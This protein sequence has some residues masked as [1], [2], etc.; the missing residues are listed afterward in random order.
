[1]H[2]SRARPD[3]L[4]TEFH[5]VRWRSHALQR[6]AR[7]LLHLP[8]DYS[9]RPARRY[10]VLYFLHGSGHDPHSVMEQ[11]CPQEHRDAL[12]AALLVVPEGNQGWWLDSPVQRQSNFGQY[13]LELVA[14]IDERY[15]T[16]ATPAGRGLCGF[17]MGGY[18]AM[19]LTCQHPDL[20]GSASSLLGPLDISQMF[21]NY[22]RLR[23][24]LGSSL[25]A[26]QEFN[27]TRLAARLA[28]T[29]LYFCTAQEAFDR[30]QNE[31]FAAA[32]R[33]LGIAFEYAAHPGTHDTAWVRAHLRDALA[34]HRRAFDQ[35]F[36]S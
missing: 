33:S 36:Q 14:L 17:S 1:M 13:V 30:L 7:F 22:Y 23:L 2:V 10:P 35:T 16:L 15:R 29:A 12:G 3:A 11:V 6:L 4:P 19:L 25:E 26:W 34:F 21:P 28:H 32:L 27:P 18:G 5:E 31:A 20:F 8:G 9:E 24:L